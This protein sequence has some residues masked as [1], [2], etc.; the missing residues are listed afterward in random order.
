MATRLTEL[1]I[2][3]IDLVDK[4]A[5]GEA[6]VTLFKRDFGGKKM[7]AEK[8]K[9]DEL[10]IDDE[11]EIMEKRNGDAMD[12]INKRLDELSKANETIAKANADLKAENAALTERVAKAEADATSDRDQLAFLKGLRETEEA[13]KIAKRCG[14]ETT[15]ANVSLV[16]KMRSALTPEEF[17]SWE[18]AMI[19]KAAQVE[20]ALTITK[21]HGSDAPA[22]GKAWDTISKRADELVASEKIAKADAIAKVCDADP[23]LYQQYVEER[24]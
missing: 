8:P 15:D 1:I 18:A 3:R 22:T 24:A 5:N 12:V 20:E 23:A 14:L 2:D 6:H 7:K 19:A 21:G 11:E 10:P 13:E 16:R 9:G 4:G 17:T